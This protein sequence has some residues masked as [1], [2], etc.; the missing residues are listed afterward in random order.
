MWAEIQTKHFLTEVTAYQFGEPSTINLNIKLYSHIKENNRKLSL[1][2]IK[3]H[4]ITQYYAVN[5][6]Q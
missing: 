6:S 1:C 5:W 4:I 3:H 2:L